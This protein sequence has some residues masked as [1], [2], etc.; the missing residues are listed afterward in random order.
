VGTGAS[1]I[2]ALE[3]RG[4][5]IL[6][7]NGESQWSPFG[8]A[9]DPFSHTVTNLDVESRHMVIYE[10][11]DTET[12]DQAAAVV[13]PDGYGVAGGQYEWIDTPRFWHSGRVIVL[14]LGD[15]LDFVG[16]LTS[17]LG[18]SFAGG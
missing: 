5:G 10:F 11:P 18:S 8:M 7:T 17:I 14:Y 2:E 4:F 1:L 9:H 16:E 3:A 6:T 12:A 15:D 13:S